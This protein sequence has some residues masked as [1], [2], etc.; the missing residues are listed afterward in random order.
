MHGPAQAKAGASCLY[1][2]VPQHLH[3]GTHCLVFF[4]AGSLTLP[5]ADMEAETGAET[6]TETDA[7]DE[8]SLE[9]ARDEE[10]ARSVAEPGGEILV[11]CALS[12]IFAN[13]F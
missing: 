2:R 12:C 11:F 6:D 13:N 3:L 10:E 9:I 1:P 5:L 4:A 8:L 7:T